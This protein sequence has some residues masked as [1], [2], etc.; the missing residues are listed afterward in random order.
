MESKFNK[1][2]ASGE[3][4][5]QVSAFVISGL[6]ALSSHAVHHPLYTLKSHMMMHGAKFQMHIFWN[7]IHQS[8]VR[9]PFRGEQLLYNVNIVYLLLYCQSFCDVQCLHKLTCMVST[10]IALIECFFMRQRYNLEGQLAKLLSTQ[11]AAG[12]CC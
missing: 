4:L 11:L 5:G 6:A 8:P 1:K 7:N 9:F 10:V 3:E 12:L 2:S